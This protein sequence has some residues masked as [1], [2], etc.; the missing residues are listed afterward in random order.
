MNYTQTGSLAT[1]ISQNPSRYIPTHSTSDGKTLRYGKGFG[2]RH[3]SIQKK[4]ESSHRVTSIL[5]DFH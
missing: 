5:H 4:N 3:M 2:R 1:D